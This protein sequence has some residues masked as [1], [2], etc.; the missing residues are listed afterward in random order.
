MPFAVFGVIN[1]TVD[2]AFIAGIFSVVNTYLNFRLIRIMNTTKK[3]AREGSD[4]LLAIAEVRRE[5]K[6]GAK[7][8]STDK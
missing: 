3:V 1:D 4:T 6:K 8:R 5:D 2:G 7:R